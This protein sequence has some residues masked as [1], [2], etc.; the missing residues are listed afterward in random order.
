[1]LLRKIQIKTTKKKTIY[2][3]AILKSIFFYIKK[4]K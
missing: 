3:K 4:L 1:M 2:Y